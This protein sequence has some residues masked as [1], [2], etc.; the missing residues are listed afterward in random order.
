MTPGFDHLLISSIKERIDNTIVQ[1]LQA[2]KNVSLP[3]VADTTDDRMSGYG[4]VG[5]GTRQWVY[6]S[7]IT[8]A[9]IP[10]TSAM[11]GNWQT[12]GHIDF[13][14]HR[15]INTATTPGAPPTTLDVSLK[16]FNVY[17]S[18]QSDEEL[19]ANLASEID[20]QTQ[21][22]KADSYYAPCIFVKFGRMMNEGFALGGE[23][24]TMVDI[25]VSVFCKTDFE[26]IAVGGVMRDMARTVTYLLDTTPLDEF[27]DLKARPWN[28]I[29]EQNQLKAAGNPQIFIDEVY[30]NPI[31]SDA[32]ASK[33]PNIYIG[34]GNFKT[35]VVRNPRQ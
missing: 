33:F 29:T 27:N 7:S 11:A 6:D 30:F 15:V 13:K 18:T 28:F 16:H 19:F 17:V 4:I 32:L 10:S 20:A 1:K 34:L 5:G 12:N 8:G 9:V 2:F 3:L 14:N 21:T 35:F 22:V 26:L 31:K 23:D 25:K 24:K